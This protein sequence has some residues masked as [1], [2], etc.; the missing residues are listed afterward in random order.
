MWGTLGILTPS[1]STLLPEGGVRDKNELNNKIMV[2][3]V[4]EGDECN[5]LQQTLRVT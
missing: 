1:L 4:G 3:L 2:V 5:C